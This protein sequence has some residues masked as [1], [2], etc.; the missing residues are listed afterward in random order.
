MDE[1][2]PANVQPAGNAEPTGSIGDAG[3]PDGFPEELPPVEPPSAGFIVQLF[4]VP[5]LIVVAVIGVWALFGKL[6]SSEQD[7]RELVQEIRSS[8]EHRRWRGATGLAQMLRAD[9]EMGESGQQLAGNAQIAKEL[10]AL[11]SE[12]LDERSRDEELVSQQSFIARTL[13]WLDSYDTVLPALGRA[14]QPDQELI[15]RAD[16]IRSVAVM[17][18]RAAE[19]EQPFD[20]ALVAS[21]LM[22]LSRD[23]E[24][25]IRQTVAFTL[26]LIPGEQVDQRLRV[27]AEDSDRNTRVNAALAM[28][29]RRMPD[30]LPIFTDVLQNARKPIDRE[31][32]EGT[33][34]EERLSQA[35]S[36]ENMNLVILGNSLRAV[37]DIVDLLSQ[38]QQEQILALCKPLADDHP[39][40]RIRIEALN[41]IREMNE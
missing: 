40:P 15:V 26:G 2:S 39:E 19:R 21:Q 12:L 27:M 16:A 5:G 4:L 9:A 14:M 34:A 30:G 17:S 18:G 13:G 3:T 31:T 7:W 32:M 37:R 33:T 1:S 20:N 11:L 6:S 23:D 36:R 10:V 24:A 29:R 28:A 41:T 35:R 22:D 8:N 38:G 25:L